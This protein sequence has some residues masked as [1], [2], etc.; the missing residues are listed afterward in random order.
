MRLLASGAALLAV[1]AGT[2]GCSASEEPAASPA[3][4]PSASSPAPTSVPT[5]EWTLGSAGSDGLTVRYR[6][7]DGDLK[8]VRVEDFPR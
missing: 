8:T 4:T 3:P 1:L 5:K 7:D 2:A 6:D